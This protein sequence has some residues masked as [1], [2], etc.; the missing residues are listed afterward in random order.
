MSD[1]SAGQPAPR[2]ILGYT[3]AA[4]T[5]L[6][7]SSYNVA[8]KYGV[9]TGLSPLLLS[10][11]RYGV[12]GVLLIP[13]Y[14]WLLA[15]GAP[16]P[17][18]GQTVVLAIFGGPLFA[19][20]A[21]S[22]YRHA[23]L[24][25]GLLFAPSAVFLIGGLI[26]LLVFREPVSRWFLPGAAL[27]F[28]GLALVS[29]FEIASLGPGSLRG[30]AMFFLAGSMWAGFTLLMRH[31]RI[32][33][34]AGTA[35]VGSVSALI[36]WPI[37]LA[38]SQDDFGTITTGT[39]VFQG[40]MQGILGGVL[41]FAFYM[42]AVR[43]LGGAR[44]SLLPSMTPGTALIIAWIALGQPPSLVE[45]TGIA[46]VTGGLILALRPQEGSGQRAG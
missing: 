33:P 23:P 18:L 46:L 3:F 17:S 26:S 44:A 38:F 34:I 7:W 35:A 10:S 9:D 14:L 22:G 37:Y 24:S 25:H 36:S 21:V 8:A 27:V 41:S 31:W 5:V 1:A 42:A 20:F 6:G 28:T 19:F 2:L 16:M 11:M 13:A 29:G 43:E 15:R 32:D 12:A 45:L 4:L 30:D 39:L 40:L